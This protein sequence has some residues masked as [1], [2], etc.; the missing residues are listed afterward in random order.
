[1]PSKFFVVPSHAIV[2]EM[3]PK[4]K[5]VLMYS[6]S[7]DSYLSRNGYL[8]VRLDDE[9]QALEWIGDLGEFYEIS[10]RQKA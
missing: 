3:R 4:G 6:H 5:G 10:P 1:M 9:A 8:C 7:Q 2:F